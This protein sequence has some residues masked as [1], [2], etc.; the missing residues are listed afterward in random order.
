MGTAQAIDVIAIFNTAEDVLAD[1][2]PD[3]LQGTVD[4][5]IRRVATKSELRPAPIG[6]LILEASEEEAEDILGAD[7]DDLVAGAFAEA[8]SVFVMRALNA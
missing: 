6:E 8:L 1:M 4:A 5:I 3:E 2:G 7:E